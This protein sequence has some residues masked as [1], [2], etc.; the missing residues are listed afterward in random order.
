MYPTELM[1][2]ESENME[3]GLEFI[4]YTNRDIEG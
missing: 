2:V 3:R 4:S 1:I